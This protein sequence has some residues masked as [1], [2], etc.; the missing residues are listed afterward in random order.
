MLKAFSWQDFLLAAIGLS[1]VWYLLVWLLFYRKVSPSSDQALGHHWDSKV[2]QLGD[3]G[4]L[5]ERANDHG[6]SV[7]ETDD[8][9]FVE[10]GA[11]ADQVEQLGDLADV[12]QEIKGICELLEKEDG[13]KDYFFQLFE[14]VKENYPKIAASSSVS[15][16]N[17]YIRE[18]VPFYLS[19]EELESLWV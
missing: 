12:Q 13:G 2:D 3:A 6:V 7:M 10:S 15:L 14:G 5:G 11:K 18:H 1:F 19:E 16:L 9:S 4:L 17:E 8:F